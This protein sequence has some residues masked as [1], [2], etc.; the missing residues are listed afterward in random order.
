MCIQNNVGTSDICDMEDPQVAFEAL[1]DFLYSAHLQANRVAKQAQVE[2]DSRLA[3][4]AKRRASQL[5]RHIQELEYL[6]RRW[7]V[8]VET[9]PEVTN[10]VTTPHEAF[11]L[12][13]LEGL[14]RFQEPTKVSWML[15]FLERKMETRLTLDDWDIIAARPAFFWHDTAKCA[16]QEL[17]RRDLVREVRPGEWALTAEGTVFWETHQ[18]TESKLDAYAQEKLKEVQNAQQ[19]LS[20][21]MT[22]D[23][24]S[25]PKASGLVKGSAPEPTELGARLAGERYAELIPDADTAK[26]LEM[27]PDTLQGLSPET[28]Y[29]ANDEEPVLTKE[30][31]PE[32]EE[33]VVKISEEERAELERIEAMLTKSLVVHNRVPGRTPDRDYIVPFLQAV[34]ALGGHKKIGVVI[35]K[36]G[37]IMKD[38]FKS[39]D[40]GRNQS[41]YRYLWQR[42]TWRIGKVLREC[43]LV[44]HRRYSPGHSYLTD[45]GRLYLSVHTNHEGEYEQSTQ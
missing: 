40:W 21:E 24:N 33:P 26:Q 7:T 11:L 1:L 2:A 32:L 43:G 20:P 37:E 14:V 13:I 15:E 16:I 18:A 35:N 3:A 28:T 34:E 30:N 29:D 44:E 45:I 5:F 22:H 10:D 25:S 41:G 4:V 36:V 6:R 17:I 27:A 12:P 39:S 38:R 8:L 19:D 23:A 9:S 31:E 42:I